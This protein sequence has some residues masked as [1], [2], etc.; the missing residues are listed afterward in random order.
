VRLTLAQR[1]ETKALFSRTSARATRGTTVAL[2]PDMMRPSF[3]LLLLP[4]VVFACGARVEDPVPAGG[5]SGTP[6]AS[7]GTSDTPSNPTP[8][9]EATSNPSTPAVGGNCTYD[10][11]TGTATVTA[12]DSTV[13]NVT[14]GVCH[15][16]TTRVSFTFAPDD[17]SAAKLPGDLTA[18]DSFPTSCLAPAGLKV[19][20]TFA[21][22]RQD[23]VTGTCAP[24][25]YEV[26]K[27]SPVHACECV[28]CDTGAGGCH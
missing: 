2:A 19:G 1:N 4:M 27:S 15:R 25:F 6:A 17:P 22:V 28:P 5:S 26:P 11:V 21:V 8:A 13:D 7:S 3:A 24:H 16:A 23:G 20:T 12:L 9:Q 18:V 10:L 14:I